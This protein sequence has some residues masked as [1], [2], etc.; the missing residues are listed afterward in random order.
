MYHFDAI[1]LP[2]AHVHAQN[3]RGVD[4]GGGGQLLAEAGERGA[5]DLL[6]SEIC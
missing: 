1:P 2:A 3:A 5:S 6:K 4:L